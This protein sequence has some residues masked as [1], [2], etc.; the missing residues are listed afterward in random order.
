M[1]RTFNKK[2]LIPFA[3]IILLLM[4]FAWLAYQYANSGNSLIFYVLGAD[5]LFILVL[6]SLIVRKV[7]IDHTNYHQ[8]QERL[9]E[10]NE[11]YRALMETSTDGTLIILEKGII[12]ANFVF[13]AMSG[14]TMADL[15]QMNFEDLIAIKSLPGL[16]LQAFYENIGDTGRTVNLEATISCKRG[17]MREIILTAS[18]MALSETFVNI[19][20]IIRRDGMRF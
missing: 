9:A 6:L 19:L 8:S 11:K 12:H 3:L 2:Y 10:A 1:S 16:N 4:A 14:Y 18:R 15:L 5:F 13:L 7:F 20:I 17:E